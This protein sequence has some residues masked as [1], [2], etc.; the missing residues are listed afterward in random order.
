MGDRTHNMQLDRWQ[1]R[2]SASSYKA[3]LLLLQG[4]YSGKQIALT[5]G[6]A[7][8][9]VSRIRTTYERLSGERLR[10]LSLVAA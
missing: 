1:N 9:N 8:S 7:E 5:T 2:L 6:V 10:R 4:G 3:L